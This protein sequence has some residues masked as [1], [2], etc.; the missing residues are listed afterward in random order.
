MKGLLLEPFGPRPATPTAHAL[1]WCGR[2]ELLGKAGGLPIQFKS[3]RYFCA[4]P[5]PPMGTSGGDSPGPVFG[6]QIEPLQAGLCPCG[7][8]RRICRSGQA[9]LQRFA[10]C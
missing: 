6:S 3:G 1:V 7:S 5:I 4:S 9:V 8:V 10:C 2:P